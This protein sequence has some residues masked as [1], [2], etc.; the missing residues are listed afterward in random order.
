MHENL[1]SYCKN[2]NVQICLKIIQFC[3]KENPDY[4]STYVFEND[5]PALLQD[6]APSPGAKIF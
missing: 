1:D 2:L 5:F 6:E 3:F 4:T